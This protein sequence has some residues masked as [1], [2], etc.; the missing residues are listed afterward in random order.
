MQQWQYPP[1]I[2]IQYSTHTEDM[3][4]Y[5][6]FHYFYVFLNVYV[7]FNI[8]IG[9]PVANNAFGHHMGCINETWKKVK[10]G[11]NVDSCFWLLSKYQHHHSLLMLIWKSLRGSIWN[12]VLLKERPSPSI[13]I[14]GA[15]Q[16]SC[17][18]FERCHSFK[19]WDENFWAVGEKHC[20][21]E[22]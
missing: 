20:T 22:L 9:H 21:F 2:M 13:L 8:S 12:L 10:N 3:L 4:L 11:L 7:M 15:G 6:S 18:I 1:H 16:V 19:V 17:I 5:V 14:Y